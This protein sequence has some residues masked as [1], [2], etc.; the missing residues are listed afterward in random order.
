LLRKEFNSGITSGN[1]KIPKK[2]GKLRTD[3]KFL[4]KKTKLDFCIPTRQI[5]MLKLKNNLKD[6]GNIY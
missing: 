1:Q 2:V 6:S 5:E 4:W 3:I